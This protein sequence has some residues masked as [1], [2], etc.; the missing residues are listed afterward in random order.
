MRNSNRILFTDMGFADN[1]CTT[2][3][4]EMLNCQ[5]FARLVMKSSAN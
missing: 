1:R 3:L 2:S 4:T 5:K